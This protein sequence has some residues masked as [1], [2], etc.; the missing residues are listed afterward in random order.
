[1]LVAPNFYWSRRLAAF[2]YKMVVYMDDILVLSYDSDSHT[3]RLIALLQRVCQLF[4]ITLH[5]DKSVLYPA[6]SVEYLGYVVHADGHLALTPARLA[7]IRTRARALLC[8]SARARRFVAFRELRSFVGTA[9]SCYAS[10]EFAHLF[11]RCLYD[12]IRAYTSAYH[13]HPRYS[14]SAGLAGRRVKLS[15]PALKELQFWADLTVE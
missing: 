14:Q 3:R 12:R 1:M 8:T 11:V 9:A 4:A 10:C 15:S 2:Q 6:R 7:K 5:P 13:A